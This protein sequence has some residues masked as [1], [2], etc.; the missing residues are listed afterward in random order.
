M[1]DKVELLDSLIQ[2]A[3]KKLYEEDYHL[4]LNRAYNDF[5]NDLKHHVGERSI[6]FRFAHYLQNLMDETGAFNDFVLDCEYNRDGAE[7]KKLPSFPNGTYPDIII[8]QR[9]T[10]DGNL[11]VIEVKTYWNKD[12]TIDESKLREFTDAKGKYKF[13]RVYSFVISKKLKDLKAVCYRC[14]SSGDHNAF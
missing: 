4:I 12:T 13:Q 8:H 11:A 14:E 1:K 2:Q 5:Y 3:L 10:N 6:V 7:G 9:G